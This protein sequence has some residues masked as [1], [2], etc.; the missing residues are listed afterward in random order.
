MMDR[1]SDF[2]HEK[3][4]IQVASDQGTLFLAKRLV[5]D[6][7]FEYG[8]IDNPYPGGIIADEKDEISNFV[9]AMDET[10]EVIGT[11]RLTPPNPELKVFKSWKGAFLPDGEEYVEKIKK[12]KIVELGALTVKKEMQN[13]MI[14][15]GLY[16]STLYFSLNNQLEYWVIAMDDRALRSLK[17]LGWHVDLVGKSIDY[18]GSPSSLGIMQISRQ[19]DAIRE[20]NRRY[21]DYIML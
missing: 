20:K 2:K 10:G 16:K 5:H 6:V 4:F 15:W 3:T 18:M 19:I 12:N 8:Y 7:Y 9:V 14:S 17:I 1:S 11:M 13:K 21:Y